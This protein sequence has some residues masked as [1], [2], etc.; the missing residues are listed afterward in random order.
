MIT[1][2]KRGDQKQLT[3]KQAVDRAMAAS[4]IF[5]FGREMID[6]TLEEVEMSEDGTQWLITLGFY[7]P[8]K[9]PASSLDDMFRQVKGITY[10]K[11]YKLF[12]VDAATG[13][14]GSM[15]IRNV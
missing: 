12:K 4:K 14:V 10:E 1:K 13:K 7:L 5:Y 9:K 3:V 11:K 15:K 6:L 8:S 2:T